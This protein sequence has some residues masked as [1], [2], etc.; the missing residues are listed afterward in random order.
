MTTPH[1]ALLIQARD[2]LD[3]ATKSIGAF[4]SDEGSS[5]QDFDNMDTCL[6]VIKYLDAAIDEPEPYDQQALELC[7]KCGWKA[8]VPGEPC[9][10]CERNA[11]MLAPEPEPSRWHESTA[12]LAAIYGEM[13]AI[14]ATESKQTPLTQQQEARLVALRAECIALNYRRIAMVKEAPKPKPVATVDSIMGSGR[15]FIS[16]LPG[17]RL[18]KGQMLYLHPPAVR[19]PLTDAEW[20]AFWDNCDLV[21]GGSVFPEFLHLARAIEAAVRSKP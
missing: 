17:A 14:R 13:C 4:T 21:D 19:E 15:P 3:L 6:A 20:F 7:D 11:R 12:E 16:R 18:E 10:M 2:A 5:Q 8:I 1:K 9:L